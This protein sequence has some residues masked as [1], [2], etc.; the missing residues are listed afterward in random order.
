MTDTP[1][2]RKPKRSTIER[3]SGAAKSGQ[4]WVERQDPASSP[5]VTIGWFRRYAAADGQLYAVL[6]TAY[7][8]LTVL[9]AALVIDSY[10]D[11]NPNSLADHVIHRLGL[12]GATE[13]LFRSVLQGA[14]GHKLGAT[15]ISLGSIAFFG[16]GIGRVLQLAHARAWGLDVRKARIADQ[17]RYFYVLLALLLAILLYAVEGK[18]LAGKASWIGWVIAPF[19][20]VAVFAFFVWVPRLLLHKEIARRDVVPGA[21]FTLLGLAVVRLL[22]HYLLVN[23]LEWYGK[24]YGGLGIVMALFFWVTIPAT[25]LVLAAALSPALAHRRQLRRERAAA[26]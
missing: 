14:G 7:L 17:A 23:W 3:A 2:D 5:G 10:L 21:V 18:V 15:L 4:L 20:L 13:T 26:T 6:L 1:P 19:W 16:L 11:S 25:I 8:F 24:Y 9:P 12:H 22:S